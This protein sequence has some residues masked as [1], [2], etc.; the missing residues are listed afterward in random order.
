MERSRTLEE[1]GLPKLEE[2]LL[3]HNL[4]YNEPGRTLVLVLQPQG[5]M[6]PIDQRV[7]VR[8]VTEA[9]YREILLPVERASITGVATA[10]S[11]PLL[12][13]QVSQW[14]DETRTGGNSAGIFSVKLP[15][16]TPN[17]L[18]A[19][20][21][22]D[23]RDWPG[24]RPPTEVWDSALLGASADGKILTIIAACSFTDGD[25]TYHVEYWVARYFAEDGHIEAVAHLPAIF[26]WSAGCS[27]RQANSRLLLTS[28]RPP[29][30]RLQARSRTER[31]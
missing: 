18:P 17:V 12:F 29:F 27:V 24:T 20:A 8:K 13:L 4:I 19:P 26:A 7:F 14:T 11:A 16:G 31:R 28:V 22:P 30:G 1:I 10:S 23:A 3:I 25:C 2:S 9:A 5:W 15:Q 6:P 21:P